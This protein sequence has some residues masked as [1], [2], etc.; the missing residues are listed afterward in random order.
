MC[1]W[2]FALHVFG[3]VVNLGPFN[4]WRRGGGVFQKKVTDHVSISF[5]N[6]VKQFH[7]R[8]PTVFEVLCWF[9]SK[10]DKIRTQYEPYLTV[11]LHSYDTATKKTDIWIDCPVFLLHV[12][13]ISLHEIAEIWL[14]KMCLMSFP[15][16]VPTKCCMDWS[17]SVFEH[18]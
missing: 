12:Q 9:C 1:S 17:Q 3:W 4:K 2:R 15:V 7:T 6:M 10:K 11:E 18:A 16:L 13:I 14:I 8:S 5:W